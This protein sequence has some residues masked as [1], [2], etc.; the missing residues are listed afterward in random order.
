MF[1][2]VQLL[3]LAVVRLMARPCLTMIGMSV[4][5]R[6]EVIAYVR[7]MATLDHVIQKWFLISR[8]MAVGERLGLVWIVIIVAVLRSARPNAL[9]VI[10]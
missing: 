5:D 10:K 3:R 7:L 8:N 2:L 1:R 4:S 6:E 9:T